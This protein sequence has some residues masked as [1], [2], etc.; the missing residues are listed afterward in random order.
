AL[1]GDPGARARLGARA[2]S[3]VERHGSWEHVAERFEAAYRAARAAR[4]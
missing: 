3:D 1:L 4:G 2:R